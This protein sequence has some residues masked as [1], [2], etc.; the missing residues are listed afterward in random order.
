LVTA[1]GLVSRHAIARR[2]ELAKAARC[3]IQY[4]SIRTLLRFVVVGTQLALNCHIGF[5]VHPR[6]PHMP[7]SSVSMFDQTKTVAKVV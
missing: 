4:N 1:A 6:N 3:K 7:T 5:Q 2:V